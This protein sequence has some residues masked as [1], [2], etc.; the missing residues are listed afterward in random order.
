MNTITIQLCQEDRDRLDAILEMM[1]AIYLQTKNSGTPFEAP[2][3]QPEPVAAPTPEPEAPAAPQEPVKPQV[4][5]AD[6]QKKVVDLSTAGKK[7]AV[8]EI[9]QKYAAKVSAIPE[10]K[11]PEVMEQLTALEG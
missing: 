6:I 11:L 8:K 5:V 10:D 3:V 1:G 2:A 4:K 9:I 7:D